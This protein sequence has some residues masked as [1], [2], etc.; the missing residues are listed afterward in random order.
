MQLTGDGTCMTSPYD[1][2]SLFVTSSAAEAEES[3]GAESMGTGMT[4]Q[5]MARQCAMS[6]F[7]GEECEGEPTKLDLSDVQ[8]DECVF[9]SGR[10]ARLVCSALRAPD[11]RECPPAIPIVLM[12]TRC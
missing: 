8:G 10:S 2:Q 11:T 1:F 9:Q 4:L 7:A 5:K 6:L 12:H 3:D